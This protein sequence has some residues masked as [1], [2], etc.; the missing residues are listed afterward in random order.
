MG[1]TPIVSPPRV[2]LD[3]NCIVSALVFSRG[4]LAWLRDA[5]QTS[6]LIPLVSRETVGELLRVLSYP[7]FALSRVEQE[8]LLAD[9]LPYAET[10]RVDRSDQPLAGLRDQDDAMFVALARQAAADAL[11][12]GDAD[13]LDLRERLRSIRILTPAELRSRIQADGLGAHAN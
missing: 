2:V 11:V 3:T 13:L 10:V 12:T 7:K 6:R 4:R 5:W 1:A 8:T 9:F